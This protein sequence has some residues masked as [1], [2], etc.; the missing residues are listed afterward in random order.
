VA[1]IDVDVE[2]LRLEDEGRAVMRLA[3]TIHY[4]DGDRRVNISIRHLRA[5]DGVFRTEL[6][7]ITRLAAGGPFER[8]AAA[9]A[10]PY[11]VN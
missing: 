11:G 5:E 9:A 2:T 10:S 3:S 7:N 6:V 4:E 1:E 8:L